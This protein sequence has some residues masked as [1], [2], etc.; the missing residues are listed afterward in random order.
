MCMRRPLSL[1]AAGYD[2]H[3]NSA[4][5]DRHSREKIA[6]RKLSSHENVD[7]LIIFSRR[8]S[9]SKTPLIS[10]ALPLLNNFRSRRRKET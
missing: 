8:C 1:K 9:E 10:I 5:I 4:Y 6:H 2:W 7:S 3:G